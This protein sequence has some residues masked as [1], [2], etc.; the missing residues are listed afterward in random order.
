MVCT[1]EQVRAARDILFERLIVRPHRVVAKGGKRTRRESNVVAVEIGKK[2]TGGVCTGQWC[3]RVL[4]QRK[5]KRLPSRKSDRI[6]RTCAGAPVDVVE[7]GGIAGPLVHCYER[8]DRPLIDPPGI[9]GGV[10]IGPREVPQ[11]RGTVGAVVQR[12]GAEDRFI[13]TSSHVVLPP[14]YFPNR[15]EVI[16]PAEGADNPR[17]VGEVVDNFELTDEQVVEADAA[18]VQIRPEVVATPSLVNCLGS[19]SD[20]VTGP[21]DLRGL[22]D[23]RQSVTFAGSSSMHHSWGALVSLDA[24]FRVRYGLRHEVIFDNQIEILSISPDPANPAPFGVSGDSGALIVYRRDDDSLC[25]VGLLFASVGPFAY[26]APLKP[27]TDRFGIT[28]YA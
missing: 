10:S 5:Y 2:I 3:V 7:A 14:G 15:R 20:V 11:V 28:F 17:I 23:R 16:Q 19:I 21:E 12:P 9:I 26:A 18:L 13:L 8:I 22:V 1:L 4:V 25:A 27:I 24:G 6:P